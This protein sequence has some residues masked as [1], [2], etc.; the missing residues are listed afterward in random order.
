MRGKVQEIIKGEL[1][2]LLGL[3]FHSYFF[4]ISFSE[5]R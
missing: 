3:E 4:A 1:Y 2:D 5:Q